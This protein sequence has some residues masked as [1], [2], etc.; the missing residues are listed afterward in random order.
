MAPRCGVF[1]QVVGLD[2]AGVEEIFFD[3][4]GHSL[5][6]AVHVTWLAARFGGYCSPS[7][8]PDWSRGWVAGYCWC[9]ERWVM[10]AVSKAA[11]RVPGVVPGGQD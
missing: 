11:G 10:T 5:L 2:H 7:H 6:A 1:A 4:G 8:V 9:S 3:P